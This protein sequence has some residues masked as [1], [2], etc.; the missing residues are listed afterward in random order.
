MP[1]IVPRGLK[2]WH[3]PRYVP[4]NNETSEILSLIVSGSVL[5]SETDGI[6]LMSTIA[7]RY[8]ILMVCLRK[9]SSSIGRGE[10]FHS[11]ER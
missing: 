7:L 3:R 9:S 4:F 8:N 1:F 11:L 6:D 10:F 2:S 5:I